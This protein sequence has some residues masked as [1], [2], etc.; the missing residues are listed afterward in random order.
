M[1]KKYIKNKTNKKI[2]AYAGLTTTFLSVV[3]P[4]ANIAMNMY[5]PQSSTVKAETVANS[6]SSQIDTS[7]KLLLGA[8]TQGNGP[9]WR[10]IQLSIDSNR[11]LNVSFDTSKGSQAIHD[12]FSG[13]LYIRIRV[14][15]ASGQ[16]KRNLSITGGQTLRVINSQWN[17]LG[18][19]L[20]LE[21]GDI[22]AIYTYET[23][24]NF[25][26][27]KEGNAKQLPQGYLDSNLSGDESSSTVYYK[28][29]QDSNFGL[30]PIQNINKLPNLGSDDISYY[31][32]QVN[33]YGNPNN[34]VSSYDRAVDKNNAMQ[35][36]KNTAQQQLRDIKPLTNSQLAYYNR[37][38][39]NTKTVSG[40]ISRSQSQLDSIIDTAKL[41]SYK[42]TKK[43][44]LDQYNDPAISQVG[45][46]IDRA[47][48]SIN[49][50]E[51]SDDVD[52]IYN[53]AL[54]DIEK[55]KL[56]AQKRNA[57]DT[58][59]QS[60]SDAINKVKNLPKLSGDENSGEKK[61]KIDEV[62]QARDNAKASIDDPNITTDDQDRIVQSGK[63]KI[64]SIVDSAN[65]LNSRKNIQNQ[66]Q[67]VFDSTKQ[68][69]L[70]SG[71]LTGDENSGEKQSAI[72]KARAVL[73]DAQNKVD[74]PE[75]NLD[76]VLDQ[77]IK[78]I[79]NVL[80]KA[81]L[82]HDKGVAKQQLQDY[83]NNDIQN[84]VNNSG[85]QDNQ[86]VQAELNSIVRD[87]QNDI[88][89]YASTSTD[90]YSKLNDYKSQLDNVIKDKAEKQQE[91]FRQDKER[92]QSNLETVFNQAK[93][94]IK[95]LPNL[96]GDET[97]GEKKAK[98]DEAKAQKDNYQKAI[99]D[100]NYQSDTHSAFTN[101]QQAIQKVVEDA[102]LLDQQNDAR[103][104]LSQAGQTAQTTI[105]GLP[106]LLEQDRSQAQTD[107]RNLVSEGQN[108]ITNSPNSQSV[109]ST[110]DSYNQQI[111]NVVSAYNGRNETIVQRN[112]DT[113]N[114]RLQDVANG[115]K[116]D[117]DRL[118]HIDDSKQNYKDRVDTEY[119]TGQ[120]NINRQTKPQGVQDAFNNAQQKIRDI[121]DEARLEDA[122]NNAKE[123]LKKAT[124]DAESKV[125]KM[126]GLDETEKSNA[127]KE[128]NDAVN[129]STDDSKNY[130]K[131]IDSAQNKDQVKSK[132][133][134]AQNKVDEQVNQA[135]NQSNSEV[136]QKQGSTK[137]DL[138]NYANKA[139]EKID[140][141]SNLNNQSDYNGKVDSKRLDAESKI[142]Q[143]K[144]QL[145]MNNAANTGKQQID[146]I[147]Q[148]A[149]AEDLANKKTNAKAD[150]KNHADTT[151]TNINNLSSLEPAEKEKAEKEVRS[152]NDTHNS[153]LERGNSQVD[154]S[155]NVVTVDANVNNRKQ[156]M[157]NTYAYYKGLEKQRVS[158]RKSA[159]NNSLNNFAVDAQK[160]VNSLTNIDQDTKDRLNQIIDTKNNDAHTQLNSTDTNNINAINNII[161][162]ATNIFTNVVNSANKKDSANKEINDYV[163]SKQ[164]QVEPLPGLTT[165]QQNNAK[166]DI[167]NSIKAPNDYR[168]NINNEL[169]GTDGTLT[170]DSQTSITTNITQ[171]KQAVDRVMEDINSQ[172][173]T[174]ITTNN[175][176]RQ[177]AV[178][179][180]ADN[181]K[182]II[183]DSTQLPNLSNPERTNAINNVESQ[184]S[185]TV[186]T[187]DLNK[188]N[189]KAA[190]DAM[191]TGITNIQNILND[192]RLN[193][194]KNQAKSA[195]DGYVSEKSSGLDQST[196]NTIKNAADS[197]KGKVDNASTTKVVENE[198]D[199]TKA[200]V[201]SII[202][203]K[204]AQDQEELNNNKD[205][206]KNDIDQKANGDKQTIESL[207]P[208][209]DND[210]KKFKDKVDEAATEAKTNIEKSNNQDS[211]D[212]AKSQ[213][214]T[215]ID[216]VVNK[217]NEANDLQKHANDKKS[218][219]SNL[220]GISSDD[221]NDYNNQ[222]DQKLK[223]TINSGSDTQTV[224]NDI[225]TIAQHAKDANDN[226]Q[227]KKN[228][229][230]N[231][232]TDAVNQANSI[233]DG[234][235]NLS[236]DERQA[237]KKQID[238][239]NQ[240][241]SAATDARN[242]IN[243][244]KNQTDID[245][246][247]K[248]GQDKINEIT[249]NGK[250]DDAKKSID[251]WADD[252][253]KKI[254][255]F[256]GLSDED[257]QKAQ[258]Q[259]DTAARQRAE[260]D[261]NTAQ[262]DGKNAVENSKTL[263]GI[264]AN[265]QDA[266]SKIDNI[267]NEY[268]GSNETAV[269]NSKNKAIDQLNSVAQ[270]AKDSIDKLQ[271]ITDNDK[272]DAKGVADSAGNFNEGSIQKLL[273]KAKNDIQG[274]SSSQTEDGVKSADKI[275]NIVQEAQKNINN[276]A[277]E[278]K[279]QDAQNDLDKSVEQTQSDIDKYSG[280]S[281]TERDS[282]KA[283]VKRSITSPTDYKDQIQNHANSFTE[284]DEQVNKAKEAINNVK[285]D[286]KNQSDSNINNIRNDYASKL[287]EEANT[288]KQTIQDIAKIDGTDADA[289]DKSEYR[290]LVNQALANAKQELAQ[291]ITAEDMQAVVDSNKVQIHKPA[292]DAK[293]LAS[294][295]RAAIGTLTD[296][297]SSKKDQI[298][299]IN[300]LPDKTSFITE[301][302][303]FNKNGNSQI[304][305]SKDN[306]AVQ[307]NVVTYK[308]YID[309]VIEAAKGESTKLVNDQK[310]IEKKNIESVAQKAIDDINK[311]EPLDKKGDF[312]KEVTDARNAAI[313]K[314]NDNTD[315]G[316]KTSDGVKTVSN[317]AQQNIQEAVNNATVENARQQA[318]KEIQGYADDTKKAIDRLDGLSEPE[319]TAA[320]QFVDDTVNGNESKHQLGYNQFGGHIDQQTTIDGIN[321]ATIRAK[322]DLNNIKSSSNNVNQ[323][324]IDDRNKQ[325]AD[326][327]I[328]YLENVRD[329]AKDAVKN[330]SNKDSANTEINTE[331]ENAKNAI[332]NGSPQEV[333]TNRQ[334]G[335]QAI[336]SV[337]D[338]ALLKDATAKNASE[339]KNYADRAKTTINSFN[340]VD[341]TIREDKKHDIGDETEGIV[342]TGLD[343]INNATS[344]QNADNILSNAKEQ[345]D[346][347][348]DSVRQSN[349]ETLQEAKNQANIKLNRSRQSAYNSIN[350]LNHLSE[351]EKKVFKDRISNLPEV[352]LNDDTNAISAELSHL[353]T[354]INNYVKSATLLDVHHDA[355]NQID[356]LPNIDNQS[357][358]NQVDNVL[359]GKVTPDAILKDFT[360]KSDEDT[361]STLGS[362]STSIQNIIDK[363][364]L[365][366]MK[367]TAKKAI[368]E[369]VNKQNQVIDKIK[370][371][372]SK[373]A[374][375]ARTK[376]NEIAQEGRQNVNK[377]DVTT[378]NQ[379]NDIIDKN[380]NNIQTI[381]DKAKDK[382][383]LEQ[384]QQ[385]QNK[386]IDGIHPLDSNDVKQTKDEIQRKVD[387][388][389]KDINN[390]ENSNK[391]HDI[392]DNAKDDIQTI[393]DKAKNKSE[394]EKTQQAKKDEVQNTN[395]LSD[396]DKK[397]AKDD[398]DQQTKAGK[399][400]IEKAT[401]Q[402]GANEALEDAQNNIQH[403]VDKAKDKSELEKTRQDQKNKVD[404]MNPLYD[405][406]KKNAKDDI[407]KQIDNGKNDIEKSKN[408]K[409]S[410][411]AKDNTK[412]DVQNIVDKY[413]QIR[414]D[415]I[416]HN[417]DTQNALLNK[418]SRNSYIVNETATNISKNA[419]NT[420]R[421][422][423]NTITQKALDD[424]KN[425]TT[426]NGLDDILN[427]TNDS[428][429]PFSVSGANKVVSYIDGYGVQNWQLQSDGSFVAVANSYTPTNS[430]VT[431]YETMAYNGRNYTKAQ[432]KDGIF[433]IQSEYL[434]DNTS[435]TPVSGVL[436]A[437]APNSNYAIYLRDRKGNMMSQYVLPGTQWRVF[438]QKVIDGKLY[439]RIGNDQQWIE[440]AYMTR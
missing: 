48:S 269:K 248:K 29:T 422:Q 120:S 328:K 309:G 31:E 199:T 305:S 16:V 116:N 356:K 432:T 326:D 205:T 322:N 395:P 337:R 25:M 347:I 160:Q 47:K 428:F 129:N 229:G 101:G 164:Q 145:E 331:F 295:K 60:A 38:I 256:G 257:K 79:Q 323:K 242:N 236:D 2:L 251:K 71:K 281:Q 289:V 67:D 137:T 184:R 317:N 24:K 234:F 21:S 267:Y 430:Q 437:T 97:S 353:Q 140:S 51:N 249:L 380:K 350:D 415:S 37:Q 330:I 149:Q 159:A 90:V 343:N 215:E 385:N 324:T 139:K 348:V 411:S 131:Q 287:D 379:L 204:N 206:A 373:D 368:D 141:L 254:N 19:D 238:S 421:N 42:N 163:K 135:Q 4:S 231:K 312:I 282:A 94:T 189:N 357:Y 23:K 340:S 112:K 359:K 61:S 377:D 179:L 33:N 88:Q 247:V 39:S 285:V 354:E 192:A 235:T 417:E 264:D 123:Q 65:N 32:R 427:A 278:V 404:E 162:D 34:V 22:V 382:S 191:N 344:E 109:Q 223:D 82:D 358:I 193:N 341:S 210:K 55:A 300:T 177:E 412:D 399:D 346:N 54:Q 122:K 325:A 98:I 20:Q 286:S 218:E 45:D 362:R 284:V 125:D 384:A 41:E 405:N 436:T 277:L 171:A 128:I 316:V 308:R 363:A 392:K 266:K 81:E 244:A 391:S 138:E 103:N 260:E 26:T 198:R 394:L 87:G 364:K 383:E 273:N 409:D 401:D 389:K 290:K 230:I 283:E 84:Q 255:D 366:S 216:D 157:D 3:Q 355:N 433:W 196:I 133:D 274:V 374:N 50:Q 40:N 292:Q 203:A 121:V 17:R 243:G 27:D 365:D 151:M 166:N 434:D 77:G 147:V 74:D 28:I 214:N 180:A 339:L 211:I 435:E 360:N 381:V 185:Q 7:R 398:I 311:L 142:E 46:I 57:K 167:A 124:D 170:A 5:L 352:S 153:A 318:K 217:A 265:T 126:P 297:A 75:S 11:Q 175:N 390:A 393:V 174:N 371:L 73:N 72:N 158:D 342:K 169:V 338:D 69:I 279:K 304:V 114:T 187:I 148:Q 161:Q 190:D 118:N 194:S 276:K 146:D 232:I 207:S 219:I 209:S 36:K 298:E 113:S 119:R 426:F 105:N 96:S 320:K 108:S 425:A 66:L 270:N 424:I 327:A 291:K 418:K 259:I 220:P 271:H 253:K 333:S 275:E 396:A 92:K 226:F 403:T 423:I 201:D 258:S 313:N 15:G 115:A 407:N 35:E 93:D 78:D 56:N 263:E 420:Q 132:L 250:K 178:N 345:I 227:A 410:H 53:Q 6:S 406:D 246:S 127:K 18:G 361:T 83:R 349:R 111:Q 245:D 85:L 221:Q 143:A 335:E 43:S 202:A 372:D 261:I 102:Q 310:E 12:K 213:G 13:E 100:S 14:V 165:D 136:T 367:E 182:R 9:V 397:K 172:N 1:S 252:A 58:L 130:N 197:G 299:G 8:W 375:D 336:N 351:D 106:G 173:S 110:Y 334:I 378:Q 414:K 59:D 440:N 222:I 321:N 306:D 416:K 64:Q 70:N 152:D 200:V 370:P 150:L 402:N 80:P 99:N 144:T 319:R 303:N 302:D 91:V 208:L 188:E 307:A 241:S 134:E 225:D 408:S 107:I 176:S 10:P 86:D 195:I 44:Q 332:T 280:L 104:K 431:A 228:E 68:D 239:G 386:D 388:A 30:I 293:D 156:D 268:N 439:Y 429:Q 400:A 154:T 315:S 314:L 240:D 63:E 294:Q 49:R 212:T 369:E 89:Q 272:N 438:A 62:T 224:K 262:N 186:D 296:Y 419:D 52:S 95:S 76:N 329:K 288:A 117:I 237:L 183:N 387:D 181:A 301:I 413:D 168:T 233:I 155:P 376:I